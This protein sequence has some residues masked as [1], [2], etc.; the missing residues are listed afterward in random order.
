M[1]KKQSETTATPD[2]AR[3]ALAAFSVNP[4]AGPQVHQF[5]EVQERILGEAED[6]SRH[7]FE[8]RHEAARAALRTTAALFEDGRPNP[9]A[10]VKAMQDWQTHSAERIAAD[11]REWVDL[12]S[13]CAG[14]LANGEVSA[15]QEALEALS[16]TA[17][18]AT[19]K[20]A[21]PV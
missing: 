18:K 1:A 6:F 8:R 5:W 3:Q 20:H 17:G 4:L 19:G 9:G 21:T 12:C 13:R 7:W 10:A 16:E 14:H 11:I 2:F 15:N